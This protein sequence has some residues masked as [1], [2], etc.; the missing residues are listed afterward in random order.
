MFFIVL[1][2]SAFALPFR[3]QE[4]ISDW[5]TCHFIEI[6]STKLKVC[7]SI[8]N[9]DGGDISCGNEQECANLSKNSE[10]HSVTG[11]VEDYGSGQRVSFTFDVDLEFHQSY[12]VS[13]IILPN[14]SATWIYHTPQSTKSSV[15]ETKMVPVGQP[16]NSQC[17]MLQKQFASINSDFQSCADMTIRSQIEAQN[18]ENFQDVL[19]SCTDEAKPIVQKARSIQCDLTG[20]IRFTIG[21]GYENVD[22][23]TSLSK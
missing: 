18:S 21:L 10:C 2:S 22:L 20:I 17:G 13:G 12:W 6:E 19:S 1:L 23:Y 5:S 15:L 9:A 7:S 4:C 8:P 16:G 11:K 14:N 3:S